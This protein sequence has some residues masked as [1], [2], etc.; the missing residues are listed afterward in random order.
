MNNINTIMKSVMIICLSLIIMGAGSSMAQETQSNTSDKEEEYF[1]A[2]LEN[3]SKTYWRFRKF[4][5]SDNVAID[6]YMRINECDLYK[7]YHHNEFEWLSIRNATKNFLEENIKKFPQNYAFVQHISLGDYDFER[8]GFNIA[9][10]QELIGVKRFEIPSSDSLS[11]VCDVRG[12]IE[13]YPKVIALELTRPL[14]FDFFDIDPQLAK[15]VLAEK[16]E[17]YEKL[18]PNYKTREEFLLAREVYLR[19]KVKMFAYK[20]DDILTRDGN[21]VAKMLA[22]LEEV[23]VF[24][25]K[26]QTQL[27]Y[28]KDLRRQKRARKKGY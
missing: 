13:K 19:V 22:I 17:K 24:A 25:D 12:P 18:D 27:L 3:F 23:E 8:K 11:S 28:R 7:E 6:N 15:E 9:K 5:L 1:P 14:T 16:M 26:D 20:P 4:D 10:E 2:S 21:Y